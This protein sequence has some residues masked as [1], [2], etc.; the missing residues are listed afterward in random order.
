MKTINDILD[1]LYTWY[2]ELW[3]GSTRLTCK[4]CKYEDICTIVC[5]AI[6]DISK[7]GEYH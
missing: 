5:H 3:C 1:Y 4:Y 6:A 7:V 2:R